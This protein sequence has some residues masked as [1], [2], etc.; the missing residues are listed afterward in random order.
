MGNLEAA[1]QTQVSVEKKAEESEVEKQETGDAKAQDA[2]ENPKVELPSE[3]EKNKEDKMVT[4]TEDEERMAIA[5]E[6]ATA[7]VEDN[8]EKVETVLAKNL[9]KVVT[10]TEDEDRMGI[11][12][13]IATV[14]IKD[15]RK[16]EEAEVAK[17]SDAE[18]SQKAEPPTEV[19]ESME[20]S[21]ERTEAVEVAIEKNQEIEV[22][23]ATEVV[24]VEA[25][26]SSNDAKVDEAQPTDQTPENAA[27]SL[28]VHFSTSLYTH[29]VP[30]HTAPAAAAETTE[31]RERMAIAKEIATT[32]VEAVR[33][34][35]E[36]EV[37]KI[38]DAEEIRKAE[39]ETEMAENAYDKAYCEA[40]AEP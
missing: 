32:L 8:G 1:D 26:D 21:V 17:I 36:A 22:A 2:E 27:H 10:G 7:L 15:N 39:T 11:A 28:G 3:G 6:I 18:D 35:E 13:E 34:K 40:Y 9:D 38:L 23:D 14:L 31:D 4:A 12:K 16:K 19:T 20:V 5:K 33:K 29:M 37:A 24:S 25:N 30:Q